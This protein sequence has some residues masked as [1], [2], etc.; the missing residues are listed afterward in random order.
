MPVSVLIADDHAATRVGHRSVVDEDLTLDFAGM[1]EDGSSALDLINARRPDVAL[2]DLRMPGRDG[3][4]VAE[5]LARSHQHTRTLLVSAYTVPE[6]IKAALERGAGGF[7]PKRTLGDE[8]ARLIH[9]VARGQFAISADLQSQLTSLLSASSG[10]AALTNRQVEV[11]QAMAG[12][13]KAESIAARLGIATSTL[14]STQNVI[15]RKLGVADRAEAVAVA[16]RRGLI[17]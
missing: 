14:R 1:A 3:L 4:E 5:E 9:A 2:L 17:T 7:A 8:L 10:A 12:G 6:I 11:L 13:H 15:Y 16:M